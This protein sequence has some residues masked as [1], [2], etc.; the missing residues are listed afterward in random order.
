MNLLKKKKKNLSSNKL[1]KSFNPNRWIFSKSWIISITYFL[2]RSKVAIYASP[3]ERRLLSNSSHSKEG[4]GGRVL[5]RYRVEKQMALFHPLNNADKP[6]FIRPATPPRTFVRARNRFC[7]RRGSRI[8]YSSLENGTWL[9]N[10]PWKQ[11]NAPFIYHAI[12]VHTS[13]FQ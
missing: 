3:H 13:Y 8:E 4:K 7:K 6:P 11:S 10:T 1:K 9:T 12:R 5:A 2:D